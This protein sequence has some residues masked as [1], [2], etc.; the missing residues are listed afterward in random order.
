MWVTLTATTQIGAMMLPT[1]TETNFKVGL[2][3]VTFTLSM[4]LSSKAPFIQP[5]GKRITRLTCAGCPALMAIL[6]LRHPESL[7]TFLAV[8]TAQ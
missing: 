1:V 6:N 3:A 7:A 8:S 5:D 4:M 2:Q